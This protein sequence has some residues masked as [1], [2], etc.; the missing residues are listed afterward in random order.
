MS[1][2]TGKG[3]SEMVCSVRCARGCGGEIGCPECALEKGPRALKSSGGLKQGC[4]MVLSIFLKDWVD[5]LWRR[6]SEA[7]RWP[8]EQLW[9]SSE[10]G[11]GGCRGRR[12][13]AR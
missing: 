8:I 7:E 5:S 1:L 11:Q 10:L 2:K 3:T 13:E 4:S 12:D 9:N 6:R